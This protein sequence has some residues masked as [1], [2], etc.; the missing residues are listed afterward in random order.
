MMVQACYNII[1][2][3]VAMQDS[4]L[5]E[6]G[7]QFIFWRWIVSMW[8]LGGDPKIGI[9]ICFVLPEACILDFN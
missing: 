6:T 4:T 7:S 8:E 3:V 9:C 1:K 2:T 5:S